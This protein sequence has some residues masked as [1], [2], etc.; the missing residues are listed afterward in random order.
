EQ[1]IE[2]LKLLDSGRVTVEQIEKVAAEW[3]AASIKGRKR[4]RGGVLTFWGIGY[5]QMLHG[6]HNTISII[7]LH[8]LTGNVGRRGCGTHSQTGQPNAMSE[9][10]MGGLTGRLPFNQPLK[11]EEWRNW[12]ADAWRVPRER[13]AQTALLK[14]PMAIG[15]MER[16]CEGDLKAMFWMYT[17]H[18]H[19]PDVET[20]VRPARTK[21]FRVVQEI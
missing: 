9:R 3:A 15:M 12:I 17:T 13:L 14:N 8:L 20:L 19:L 7:N 4:G 5:N 10:L 1:V 18:I 11:N 6:Q 16:G 2:R 21:T